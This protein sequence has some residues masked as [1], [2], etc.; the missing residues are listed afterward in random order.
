MMN[1]FHVSAAFLFV[2]SCF[3]AN[4]HAQ[5][6]RWG[7]YAYHD[8]VKDNATGQLKPFTYHLQLQPKGICRMIDA[9]G[10]WR[11]GWYRSKARRICVTN[12]EKV[13]TVGWFT[14][15]NI[16]FP[17]EAFWGNVNLSG[18]YVKFT[19]TAPR[20]SITEE[21][22]MP[23][24]KAIDA[25]VESNT[26]KSQLRTFVEAIKRQVKPKQALVVW[27]YSDEK[28]LATYDSRKRNRWSYK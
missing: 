26:T 27:F 23:G 12:W 17:A 22:D 5:P 1:F 16:I 3:Q 2:G 14:G 10:K 19:R 9:K 11:Y 18:R 4:V 21:R 7:D 24:Y 28:S 15:V 8:A 20:Y 6:N 25:W 13:N